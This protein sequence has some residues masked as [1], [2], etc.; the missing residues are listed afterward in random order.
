MCPMLIQNIVMGEIWI[1]EFS[2][3]FS[4]I[5]MGEQKLG[6]SGN[7]LFQLPSDLYELVMQPFSCKS[8]W[9]GV[10][11]TGAVHL[12]GEIGV[13]LEDSSLM[14][15]VQGGLTP[16]VFEFGAYLTHSRR[17]V[18]G[19]LSIESSRNY[20]RP[21]VVCLYGPCRFTTSQNKV[22]NI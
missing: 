4:I 15:T 19:G 21:T 22:S 14:Y 17:G 10:F 1:L 18:Y 8:D 9:S 7:N 13:N 6:I 2:G 12:A 5:D 11:A 16:S 3:I 20:P